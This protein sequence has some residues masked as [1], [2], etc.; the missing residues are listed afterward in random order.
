MADD[1][2]LD[3]NSIND[4]SSSLSNLPVTRS[5]IGLISQYEDEATGEENTTPRQVGVGGELFLSLSLSRLALE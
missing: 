2:D 3:L 1:D 5:I 4:S